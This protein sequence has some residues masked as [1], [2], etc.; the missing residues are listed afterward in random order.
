M[1]VKEILSFAQDKGRL[2][3]GV[4]LL[5]SLEQRT[6]RNG[7]PFAIATF[8]D[9]SGT[10]KANF[11]NNHDQFQ[12]LIKCSE[13]SVWELEGVVDSFND[14]F[15]P[16]IREA[17]LMDPEQAAEHMGDLVEAAPE[18]VDSLWSSL[19]E[20]IA[21]IQNETLRAVVDDVL[22]DLED[23]FK[24]TPAAVRMHHAYRSG[25]LEH[26]VHMLRAAEVLLPLYPIVDADLAK[27]GIILHDVG[28]VFEY[29]G[30]LTTRRSR[31]GILQGHVVLGYRQARKAGMKRGLDPLLMERLE[32]IILSHQGQ[33]EW[34]AA[35]LAA[36]PEAVFVSMVDNLDAKMGMVEMT[37]RRTPEEQDQTERVAG[38]DTPLIIYRDTE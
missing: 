1:I 34:G 32:H 27:A 8:G 25:L 7:D 19:Q 28:K 18:S 35:A 17:R 4:F 36:T 12:N 9:S 38:L 3:S 2:F 16:Q 13:G 29:E 5:Q 31:I 24:T 22:R 37:L 20:G 21:S 6:T 30:D 33:M 14:R 11:F 23:S 10:F 26:T 15:S